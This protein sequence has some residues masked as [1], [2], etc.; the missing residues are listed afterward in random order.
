MIMGN[1][2]LLFLSSEYNFYLTS[3]KK[4]KYNLTKQNH[5][6][7]NVMQLFNFLDNT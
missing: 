1:A 4:N 2:V 7:Q 3:L 6:Y 5:G